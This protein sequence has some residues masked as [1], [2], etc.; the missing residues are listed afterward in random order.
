MSRRAAMAWERHAHGISHTY[1]HAKALPTDQVWQPF[2]AI[3][4]QAD[5]VIQEMARIE[6]AYTRTAEGLAA[7]ATVTHYLRVEPVTLRA[8][9]TGF[10]LL[11]HD[12]TTRHTATTIL[13][14]A[15]WCRTQAATKHTEP[16]GFRDYMARQ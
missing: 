16:A 2:H 12:N 10:S 6:T 1:E 11:E 4:R 13:A 14:L 3:K 9:A 7:Y 8:D 15:D 5:A